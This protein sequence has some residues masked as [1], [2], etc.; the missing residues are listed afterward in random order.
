MQQGDLPPL[1][2]ITHIVSN[3]FDFPDYAAACDAFIPVVKPTWVNMS[4]ARSRLANPRQ[5]NP[6]PRLFMS[7]VVV[8]CADIPEGDEDAIK[9]GVLAMG[10]MFTSKIATAVTHLVALTMDND[11]CEIVQSRDLGIKIVLPHWF[12]DCLK[13]GRRI[14]EQPYLLPNPEYGRQLHTSPPKPS[15]NKQLI[16]ASHPDPSMAPRPTPPTARKSLNVFKNKSIMLARN[17]G[18]GSHLR[19]ILENL[20]DT[21]QG[22]V[23]TS[24]H[25]ANMY[26]CKYREGNDYKLASRSGKD[27]GNL[28]WLYYLITNN[29]WTS[30]MRRLLHYPIAREGLVG[31]K[32]LRISLSNYSG[33]ARSYLEQLVIATG[34]ESTKTL[35]QDNTHLITAHTMSEKCAAANDWGNQCC[36]PL[37][38]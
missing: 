12:D 34:A 20:I 8:C 35:K 31:F 21:G 6:D 28:A 24:V 29:A 15:D 36:Q 33:E 9:G 1:E 25:K 26:V 18:I 37:V 38:A 2:G 4:I 13:L 3:T 11:K 19:E 23:V 16:G 22:K 7:E 27:V 5:F 10:G 30:P 32:D 14:D 17:L